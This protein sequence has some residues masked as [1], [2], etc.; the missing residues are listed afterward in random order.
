MDGPEL[1][2]DEAADKG[3]KKKAK[4]IR[5]EERKGVTCP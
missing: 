3:V 5:K 2:S 1:K 4:T